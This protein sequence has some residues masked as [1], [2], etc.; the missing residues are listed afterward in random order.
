MKTR[1]RNSRHG[2]AWGNQR[3]AGRDLFRF[4][5][6]VVGVAAVLVPRAHAIVSSNTG[7]SPPFTGTVINYQVGAGTFY[8]LGF[9]GGRATVANIEAG[10]IWNG[11]ETLAGRVS[12]YLADPAIV[13]T[14]TTQLGQLD[15]HATMVG[16][17]IG[18]A[19][20]LYFHQ[21]G[22]APAAQLW[23][24]S[25]ATQ[26]LASGTAEF[27]VGFDI[28][29]QSFFYAYTKAMRNGVVSGSTTLR[30]SVVN[31]SW[32][33]SGD[34]AGNSRYT[35]A[36]DALAL[37]DNVVTVVAAG[38]S[39]P[40]AN[41]VGGPATGY[42]VI[43]AAALTGDQTVPVYSQ[44]A[45]FSSRGP[46]DFFNPV[47]GTM[48]P[49]VR[50][51]VDITAPGDDLTLAFY[52]GLTGG[53]LSGTAVTG[54]AFYM[55][56]MDGTSFS[57]PIVAGGA[58][59]MVDA[60]TLFVDGGAASSEMLDA[61]VIK[62]AMLTAARAP[63]G[64]NNGQSTVGGVVTTTQ[65]LDYAS[66][67][68]ILDL[69]TAYRV[70][71]GDPAAVTIDGITY[72]E[73]GIN[74]T[75]G[76]LGSAGGS[77][78]KHRGWDLGSVLNSGTWGAGGTN[79][80]SFGTPLTA[81]DTLTAALTWFADRTLGSSLTSAVDVALSNLVL[82][83]WRSDGLSGDALVA[84]SNATYST[85]EFLRFAVPETGTYSMRVV[86][87]DQIY[88]VAPTPDTSTAYALAWQAVPVPEPAPLVLAG[89]ALV[90]VA[91]RWRGRK[92]S[93]SDTA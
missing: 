88:N 72:I 11:H 80:Y 76:V 61:R 41:T 39:G 45:D 43:A 78:L 55:P 17:T 34:S 46:S 86:G 50:P 56:N 81:G 58:A 32:G 30:A 36:I 83:V 6:V 60:G 27:V 51:T 37:E 15:W 38:N 66:G 63:T 57:A 62:A 64:W 19:G 24:A 49:G 22:I 20:Q 28:T 7:A 40:M 69:D 8:D 13:D 44:V 47:S 23:S 14:G 52:G 87:L 35:I 89:I 16:Q 2:L 59:L 92:R 82:E 12:Q 9:F 77:G 54:T 70:Y 71:L 91:T 33:N 5:L 1:G 68:G 48:I 26:W 29:D 53:R 3:P 67:A 74:T 21:A 93:S 65:A 75:L 10:A 90:A 85:T 25:I 73:A 4:L 31:S 18:G 42:N 79:V 84:Q